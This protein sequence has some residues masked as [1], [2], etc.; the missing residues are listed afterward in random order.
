MNNLVHLDL[1]LPF[2][3]LLFCG[4]MKFQEWFLLPYLVGVNGIP[5]CLVFSRGVGLVR[6]RQLSPGF[7]P[8]LCPTIQAQL[9][10]QYVAVGKSLLLKPS[11]ILQ[12]KERALY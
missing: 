7:T 4:V 8:C 3:N 10:L 9:I 1:T 11:Q 6:P 2:P 5:R 12:R